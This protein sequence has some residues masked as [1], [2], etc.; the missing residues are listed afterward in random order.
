MV[1]LYEYTVSY[2][3]L[4]QCTALGTIG[5]MATRLHS[6]RQETGMRRD[7]ARVPTYTWDRA[8]LE[9]YCPSSKHIGGP[10]VYHLRMSI[11]HRQGNDRQRP[12][13][14]ST[15]RGVHAVASSQ[16]RP[17]RY[18]TVGT[19]GLGSRSS[20]RETQRGRRVATR[21]RAHACRAEA[22]AARRAR[23]QLRGAAR[24]ARRHR[25]RAG[26]M[27]GRCCGDSLLARIA[28]HQ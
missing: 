16:H 27:L 28:P 10:P 5:P 17:T 12:A 20:V 6:R 25:P 8:G 9:A 22:P 14:R 15:S 21:E 24:G 26:T 2:N 19:A 23:R 18:C 7:D 3:R 11:L 4:P 13:G 1:I